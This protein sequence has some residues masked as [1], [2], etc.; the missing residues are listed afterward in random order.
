M[1]F[2]TSLFT[3]S[4]AFLSALFSTKSFTFIRS[5][6]WSDFFNVSISCLFISI[7]SLLAAISSLLLFKISVCSLVSSWSFTTA[8]FNFP[9]SS[10]FAAVLTIPSTLS[11]KFPKS[12]LKS[13]RESLFLITV[14]TTPFPSKGSF[15]TSSSVAGF[16]VTFSVL[17]SISYKSS[18]ALKPF[19]VNVLL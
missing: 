16:L 17:G 4:K 5:R 3:N 12:S 6:Y 7:A 15:L 1:F 11:S 8:S 18:P 13:S 19:K 14:A 10:L 2:S 9:K